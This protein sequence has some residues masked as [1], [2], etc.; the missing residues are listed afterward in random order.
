MSGTWPNKHAGD[1]K[2]SMKQILLGYEKVEGLQNYKYRWS[3]CFLGFFP[4]KN[5]GNYLKVGLKLLKYE[6][7]D[8][9]LYN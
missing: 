6:I 1:R 5:H 8:I 2:T 7:T 4:E 9:Y 3:F